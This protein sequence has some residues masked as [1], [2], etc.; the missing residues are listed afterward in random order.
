MNSEQEPASPDQVRRKSPG[1]VAWGKQL[2]ALGMGA[3]G[4]RLP[5]HGRRMLA[6]LL[7]RGLDDGSPVAV[8]RRE[9]SDAYLGDLGGESNATT[10]D[11][12][13]VRRLVGL[14]LDWALLDAQLD[15][16]VRLSQ[17]QA[18]KLRD[19]RAR[20]AAAYASLV[21]VLGGP[22]RRAKLTDNTYVVHRY[23]NESSP[24]PEGG[25]Q[26]EHKA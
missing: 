15:G 8:L 11:K 10:M 26:P 23:A 25:A 20:N 14:D 5:K 2:Q 6:E 16:A 19:E 1:R 3:M 24:Q 13:V 18:T 9:A 17:A 7:R 22:G 21:K 4:G 12:G